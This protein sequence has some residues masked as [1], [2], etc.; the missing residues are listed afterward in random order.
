MRLAVVG[1]R[2]INK[3][4][5]ESYINFIPSLIV[6]G[7]A[8]G[9]DTISEKW[10]NSKGIKTLIFKPE[11]KRYKK[12]APLVRNKQI[13]ESCDVLFAFWDGKSKGTM[14]AVHYAKELGKDVKIFT[15]PSPTTT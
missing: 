10:A 15:S 8:N 3:I 14:N 1:S 13:V 11:Y 5:F 2:T 9:V 4:D 12:A 6:S 7:G